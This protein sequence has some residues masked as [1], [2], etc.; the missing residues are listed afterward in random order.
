MRKRWN[1]VLGDGFYTSWKNEANERIRSEMMIC[2]CVMLLA[3]L[4]QTVSPTNI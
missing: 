1:I 4:Q 3:S 2:E